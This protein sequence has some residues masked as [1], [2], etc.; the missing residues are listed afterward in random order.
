M[1]YPFN[2]DDWIGRSF[3]DDYRSLNN[4]YLNT[5]KLNRMNGS[6]K[7][8]VSKLASSFYTYEVIEES[9]CFLFRIIEIRWWRLTAD[10]L[11][12]LGTRIKRRKLTKTET[13]EMKKKTRTANG[14]KD[15]GRVAPREI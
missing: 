2:L 12:Y 6:F 1:K 13:G 9:I 3:N 5:F 4:Q 10:G 8:E 11:D 14:G 15:G 7:F